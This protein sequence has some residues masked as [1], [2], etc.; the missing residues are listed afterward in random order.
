M[1]E[2]R[3]LDAPAAGQ[4]M[5][6]CCRRCPPVAAR[7]ALCHH[8]PGLPDNPVDQP[9]LQGQVGLDLVDPV[10][11][12]HRRGHPISEAEWHYQIAILKWLADNRPTDP[13]VR[14]REPVDLA[15]IPI[16]RWS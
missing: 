16:P 7:I 9:Y 15:A 6:R 12:W 10:E 14:Y 13:R 8:E 2:P 4:W 11:I 5:I 1:T 3:Q